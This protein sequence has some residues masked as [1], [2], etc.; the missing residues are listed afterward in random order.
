MH[1]DAS[2]FHVKYSHML[3]QMGQMIDH[4]MTHSPIARGGIKNI[5]YKHTNQGC[6][7]NKISILEI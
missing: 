3:M 5:K 4:D 2:K 1:I 7:E 6:C